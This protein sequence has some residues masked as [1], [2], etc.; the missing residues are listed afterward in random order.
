MG[1]SAFVAMIA[2]AAVM[3][4]VRKLKPDPIPVYFEEAE[5]IWPDQVEP[6]WHTM[7]YHVPTD[8]DPN[9]DEV[10]VFCVVLA[11][12][13]PLTPTPVLLLLHLGVSL[14]CSNFLGI[15]HDSGNT[16]TFIAPLP[17]CELQSTHLISLR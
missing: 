16:L 4:A 6:A 8:T 13:H 1:V 7:G 10:C 15:C 12:V 11:H 14:S 3:S 9:E 17:G 2:A 5:P